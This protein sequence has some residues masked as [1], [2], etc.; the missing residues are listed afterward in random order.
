MSLFNWEE[1]QWQKLILR[2]Q[3]AVIQI[4]TKCWFSS[5]LNGPVPQS[6]LIVI[7]VALAKEYQ[8][9]QSF[10]SSKYNF[11]MGTSFTRLSLG[12]SLQFVQKATG[13]PE[14]SQR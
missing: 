6:S 11:V 2:G 13:T 9:M 8:T 5:T 10:Y 4:Y 14:K 7:D 1:M 3:T 12:G